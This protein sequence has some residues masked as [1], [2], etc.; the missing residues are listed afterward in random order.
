[1]REAHTVNE[2]QAWTLI[3]V[4]AAVMLG[5][6]SL[7]T[8]LIMRSTKSAIDGLRAEMIG[9]HAALRAEMIGGHAALRGEMI[10]GHAALRGEITGGLTGLRAEMNARFDGVDARLDA[11]DARIA[12]LDRDVTFLMTRAWGEPRGE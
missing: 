3:G 1:M 2:P 10:G 5:G 9:G 12:H 4:F 11:T 6:M 7:T 8:T